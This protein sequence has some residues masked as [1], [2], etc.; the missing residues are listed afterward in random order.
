MTN[1]TYNIFKFHIL[2][3]NE[4]AFKFILIGSTNLEEK[5]L[6]QAKLNLTKLYLFRV[7]LSMGFRAMHSAL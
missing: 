2:Y 5:Q 1:I 3:G 6:R 7:W 4:L